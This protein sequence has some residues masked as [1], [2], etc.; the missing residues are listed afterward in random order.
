MILSPRK[1]ALGDAPDG[2]KAQPPPRGAVDRVSLL[3]VAA[4]AILWASDVFFRTGLVR[5]GLSSSAIVFAEDLLVSVACIPFLARV[6]R[7]L[8]GRS[9]RDI[10]C[11]GCNARKENTVIDRLFRV[12][13]RPHGADPVSRSA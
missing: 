5:H 6:A 2:A 3:L 12:G 1:S 7:A 9:Q 13:S 8:H 4:G 10:T 11:S